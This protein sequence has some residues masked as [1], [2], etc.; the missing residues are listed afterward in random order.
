MRESKVDLDRLRLVYESGLS[1]ARAAREVGC[2]MANALHHLRKMGL[3]RPLKRIDWP[4]EQMRHW[5][6]VEHLSL[7]DIADRLGQ[8]QKVVNKVAKRHGFAMKPQGSGG[9]CGPRSAAYRTG[10]TI[11]KAGYVLV[12]KPDHPRANRSGYVREHRLVAEQM[13]GR[14]LL[15]T[16][17]V[18]HVNDDPAD[19]R[20]ENLVVFETNGH[21][22]A[23]T[24]AG[25]CPQWTPDGKRRILAAI[26]RPRKRK[27]SP[28]ASVPDAPGSP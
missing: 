4:I 6:E 13:L 19:N 18:H 7:Q 23:A 3:V 15:P 17:V 22:L 14:L 2:S 20:P 28:A 24:L 8:K 1:A 9:Y 16:E 10:K 25:K 26:R 21:H 5:Y 12:L 11:D 27:D